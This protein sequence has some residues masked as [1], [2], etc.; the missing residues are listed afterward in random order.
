MMIEKPA[1]ELAQL[2]QTKIILE[3]PDMSMQIRHD[4]YV[5]KQ[6]NLIANNKNIFLLNIG[7]AINDYNFSLTQD[8]AFKALA[9]Q[10]KLF[11]DRIKFNLLVIPYTRGIEYC[12]SDVYEKV[13]VR[14]I[15]Y[16]EIKIDEI[17]T[18]YDVLISKVISDVT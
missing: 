10:I 2:L 3:T 8:E 11:G 17:L 14:T 6:L 9:E 13:T 18:R 16:Y 7:P 5:T 12:R 1:K 4:G 15:E